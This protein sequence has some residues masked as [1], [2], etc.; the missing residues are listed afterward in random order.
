MI[1]GRTIAQLTA[2]IGAP[3]EDTPIRSQRISMELA[4]GARHDIVGNGFR[5]GMI[6]RR[7]VPELAGLV[8]AP[9]PERARR[10]AVRLE[11]EQELITAAR[12]SGHSGKL[13]D[14]TRAGHRSAE[15]S[16]AP[17]P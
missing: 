12:D 9:R 1:G 7:A 17:D 3:R 6:D 2:R 10:H 11:S 4:G 5:G 15:R 14:L 8:V 16:L 13:C